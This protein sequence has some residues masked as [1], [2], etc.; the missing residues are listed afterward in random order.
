MDECKALTFRMSPAFLGS[1]FEKQSFDRY[2][3]RSIHSVMV[4]GK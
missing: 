4:S 3:Q 2:P 1:R